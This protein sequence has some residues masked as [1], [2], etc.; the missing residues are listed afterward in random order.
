MSQQ[1]RLIAD[2]GDDDGLDSGIRVRGGKT[3]AAR[4]P[5]A[6]VLVETQLP[7]L[8]RP[9]D[10]AVTESLA[11]DAQP[12]VRVRV[13][14]AGRLISGFVVSRKAST[15]HVG[16]LTA[17]ER[18]V[19]DLVVLTPGLRRLCEEIAARYAGT[20]PDVLRL[21]IPPRHATAERRARTA[22]P[23]PLGEVERQQIC[24]EISAHSDE[25]KAFADYLTALDTW[26]GAAPAAGDTTSAA[27]GDT[28]STAAGHSSSSADSDT[29]STTDSDTTS[30][31]AGP[32]AAMALLPGSMPGTGWIHY[33]LRAAARVLRTGRSVLWLVPDHRELAALEAALGDL[34]PL[35]IRLSADQGQSAR[36]SAWVRALHGA[37]RLIIGTRAA[38]FAPASDIGLIIC[39]DDGDENY[40]DQH[41]PYPHAR[42][43]LLTRI[44]QTGSAALFL[45]YNR[46]VEIQRLVRIGWFGEIT[47]PGPVHRQQA[48]NCQ[49]PPEDLPPHQHQR[50]PELGFRLTQAAIGRTKESPAIGPVLVQVPRAGYLPVIAC[51][52]CRSVIE[53]PQCAGKLE[54]AS[55]TGPFACRT[56]GFRAETFTCPQCASNAVRAVVAGIER[57]FE[58]LGRAFPGTKVIRS[59]GSHIIDRVPDEPSIVVATTGA[60]PYADNG[61]ALA[62][63]LDS[64]WPGPG[65]QATDRAIARR[66]RAACLVRGWQHGGR[67]L[68]MDDDPSIR[69]VIADFAPVAWADEQYQARSELR[70]PPAVRTIALRGDRSAVAEVVAAA[71]EVGQVWDIYAHEE[72]YERIIGTT[73]ASGPA[74][75]RRIAAE[76]AARSMRQEESVFARVDDPDVL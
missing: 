26:I 35:A 63:L 55:Q 22:D 34:K 30:A 73:I 70:F 2:D 3:P 37:A 15:E 6:E 9:F 47:Y 12:G 13:R 48:P 42:Q 36:W 65:L 69:Q 53:C 11:A 18:V 29:S 7:H 38:A 16:E 68:L 44:Q 20:L 51:A 1:P 52:G 32:R 72:P 25:P 28:T 67:I 39:L 43:V 54:A 57:T 27:G 60:E 71:S 58:E 56:C 76:V 14:F 5:V 45:D 33:G 46:T 61:Y 41:A 75:T 64:L 21:A 59:G 17:I 74:V 49:L 8:A 19:S 24:D 62:L 10:Y 40:L 50:L 66:M 31:A 4:L 23:A